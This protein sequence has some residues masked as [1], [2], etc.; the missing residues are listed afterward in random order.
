MST[1][2]SGV[3]NL[4]ARRQAALESSNNFTESE[5]V[6]Q[7]QTESKR[8]RT[9]KYLKKQ[10]DRWADLKEQCRR[11]E[12]ESRELQT[13][14]GTAELEKQLHDMKVAELKAELEKYHKVITEQRQTVDLLQKELAQ[15]KEAEKKGQKRPTEEP[16]EKDDKKAWRIKT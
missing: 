11:L 6:D 14:K 10:G 4:I 13:L 7:P 16:K 2:F 3:S 8:P 1:S 9:Q 15:M 5:G 12:I